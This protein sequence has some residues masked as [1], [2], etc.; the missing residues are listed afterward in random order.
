MII[1]ISLQPNHTRFHAIRRLIRYQL[2]PIIIP[3]CLIL[4]LL[5]YLSSTKHLMHSIYINLCLFIMGSLASAIHLIH[6]H[7]STASTIELHISDL[8][9]HISDLHCHISDLHCSPLL[10]Y[11][12]YF[13]DSTCFLPMGWGCSLVLASQM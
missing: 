8:H 11:G 6:L 4:I 9:C 12:S 10:A 3:H 7:L 1:Q 2:T 5:T 13:R